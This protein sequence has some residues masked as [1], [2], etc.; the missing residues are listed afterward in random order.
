MNLQLCKPSVKLLSHYG[1]D[2]EIATRTWCSTQKSQDRT[3]DDVS[4]VLKFIIANRHVKPLELVH[5]SFFV[6]CSIVVDRQLCTHRML[7]GSIAMSHRYND[8]VP[9]FSLPPDLVEGTDSYA[10]YSLYC[11]VA[12]ERYEN[13]YKALIEDGVEK[14]R[15]REIARN[16]LPVGL[17]TKREFTV[18]LR[19]IANFFRLRTDKHAQIEI[20][21]L[22]LLMYTE[23]M[24]VP[25][26]SEITKLLD[27][28]NWDV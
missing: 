21:E 12:F 19:V 20:Q 22:A 2:R 5:F 23:V 1:S 27:E 9:H 16:L 14:R 4:R 13:T 10:E 26:L 24:A 28:A 17:M 6:E 11:Q 18:N 7:D 3:D 15:A 25:T 8:A